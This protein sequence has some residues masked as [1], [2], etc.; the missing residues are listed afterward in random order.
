[1]QRADGR[2]SSSCICRWDYGG[3]AAC[4]TL[5][6]CKGPTQS[7]SAPRGEK[8]GDGGRAR[9]RTMHRQ[10]TLRLRPS[11]S[12]ASDPAARRRQRWP[13]LQLYPWR[14]RC[15]LRSGRMRGGPLCAELA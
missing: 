4:R 12:M 14:A 15:A 5:A 11:Q 9:E 3:G 10:L 8:G 1:M 13:D 7:S 2:A 6:D